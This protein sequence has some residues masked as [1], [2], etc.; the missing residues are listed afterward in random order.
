[1]MI[2]GAGT[3]LI[4]CLPT[5]QQIGVWAPITLIGLWL[6]QGIGIGGEWGGATL[7]VIEHAPHGRR[8]FFGSLVQ[9]GFP[10]GVATS[11]G[12]FLLVTQMSEKHLLNWV[13]AFH[14]S[15]ASSWSQSVCSSD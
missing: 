10:L 7:M 2:M 13:G 8:G 11:T 4:G 5:Y 15:S 6:L 9:V 1:M 3:F 12:V 14:S